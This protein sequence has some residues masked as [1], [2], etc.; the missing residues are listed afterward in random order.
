MSRHGPVGVVVNDRRKSPSSRCLS[1]TVEN[2]H[3]DSGTKNLL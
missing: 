1:V 2:H 3:L